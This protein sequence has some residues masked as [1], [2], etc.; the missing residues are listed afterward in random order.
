MDKNTSPETALKHLIA[1]SDQIVIFTGAGMSTESGVSDYRSQGG[2]WQRYQPVTIREFL[3]DEEKRREY[4]L[5]K[6][7]MYTEMRRAKPNIGHTAIAKLEQK[8]KLLGVITQNID[9]LHQM[10]GNK[11][12]LEIHGTNR[13]AICLDCNC[14][15]PF[16][17]VFAR[18][19]GG[20]DIPLCKDCGGL[21]K[22]NTISFG[23]ALD[24]DVID[25]AFDW[26]R[27]SDLFLAVG[28]TLIVEPAASIPRAAKSAGKPLVIVNRDPTPLDGMADLVISATIG[29]LL[30]T[31]VK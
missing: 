17:P 18:L 22:P 15:I 24:P 7:E 9:G 13:E 5:R 30:D 3:T 8:G 12:I 1:A 31:V 21:L 23:Q 29:P 10:A 19:A 4:W 2:L 28:S 26:A 27:R 6:K 11:H 25:K 16:D 20:E 14:V